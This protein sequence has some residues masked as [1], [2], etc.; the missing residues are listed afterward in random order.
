M[1]SIDS[2]HLVKNI[3]VTVEHVY[4]CSQEYIIEGEYPISS[5]TLQK[6]LELRRW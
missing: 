6:V 2:R 3:I 4:K 1:L 5:T